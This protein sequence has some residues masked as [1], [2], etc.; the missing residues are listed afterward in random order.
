M[1]ENGTRDELLD[2]LEVEATPWKPK[3]G[4]SVVGEL[5]SAERRTSDYGSY[6]MLTMKTDNGEYVAVHC[7]HTVLKRE[8]ARLRPESGSRLG[9]KYLGRNPKGYEHYKV[10]SDKPAQSVDWD[11]VAIGADAEL[12]EGDDWM[13]GDDEPED[14]TY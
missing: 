11:A 13:P 8:L 6:P 3:A 2:R 9:I 10:A 14:E 12:S 4:D 7:F 1:Q 5:V